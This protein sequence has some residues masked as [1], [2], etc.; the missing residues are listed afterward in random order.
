MADLICRGEL[1]DD[2]NHF[3]P[4]K[5]DPLVNKIIMNQHAVDA[6][7]VS[8]LGRLGKLMMPYAGCPRGRIGASGEPWKVMELDAITDVDGNRWVPVLDTDLERLKGLKGC[9]NE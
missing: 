5:Y 9:N 4:E 6:V 2:L 1:I 7:E 8:R 3:A